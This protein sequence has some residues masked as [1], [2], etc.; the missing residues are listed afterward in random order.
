MEN[1]H[2]L[3]HL[4]IIIFF[5]KILGAISRKLKQPP[6]IGMLLLGILLGPT[7]LHFIEPDAVISWIAKIG[8]LFL[9]FEAGLETD[10]K[11]IKQ[12]SK[13]AIL[14][15]SGGILLP[16]ILGGGFTYLLFHNVSQALIVGVIFTAT[17]VSVSVMTL[18]DLKKLKGLE[19]RCIVN[20]AIIDD[21]VGILLLTIIFGVTSH[22]TS[23]EG[24]LTISVVKIIF[25]F[26]IAFA[27]GIFVLQPFF[28][29]LKK[30]NLDNVVISLAIAVVMLYSW[31][32]E[33]SGLAAITGAYFAGL[34]LGQTQHKNAVQTGITNIGKSF[35]V[36]VFFVNIGLEFNL[37]DIEAEPFFLTGFVLLAIF[38]KIIGSGVGAKLTNFDLIRSFRIGSGMIPRGEVALIVANMALEKGLVSTDILSATIMMVI[39]SALITPFLLKIGFTKMGKKSF[40]DNN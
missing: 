12:D 36:D 33:I 3:L 16:F 1:S 25:F 37:F 35:F 18:I 34:F 8:V 32:A 21:I 11:R 23:G 29:N 27:M 40:A 28:L 4:A 39:V 14:P 10:L 22:T 5:S 13:Q 2:L 17:S 9:L 19:G 26:V 30:I 6:V 24:T 15:A 7:F 31:I 38:G 20:S